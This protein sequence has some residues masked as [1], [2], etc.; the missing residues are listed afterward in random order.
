[1]TIQNSFFVKL[2]K[3]NFCSS[4]DSFFIFLFS[5]YK[6]VYSKNNSHN[7]RTLKI[8]IGTIIK[9]PEMLIFIPD[10]LKT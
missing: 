8:S 9:D 1:M 7:Y 2:Q 3:Y 10:Y 6:M 4:Q 5:L